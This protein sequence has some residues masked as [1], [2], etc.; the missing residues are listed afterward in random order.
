[1]TT[2]PYLGVEGYQPD[3]QR[4][5]A[6]IAETHR[7]RL[8]GLIGQRLT[9]AWLLWDREHDEWFA[10]APVLLEFDSE[11]VEVQH[12]K[13]DELSLTWNTVD[14][15]GPV[16][17]EDFVLC[18]RSDAAAVLS[19]LQGQ[20]VRQ[21]SLLEWRGRDM[22]SGMVAVH[23]VFDDGQVTVYNAL[24]ENGLSFDDPQ[25]EYSWHRIG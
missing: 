15:G 23:L 20:S 9:R 6:T 19:G 16:R 22:A 11:Q 5:L 25:P 17:F 7:R 12:H 10:D 21:V 1:M 2:Y 14:P 4:G 24:D 8:A 18:W 3:Y 13:F